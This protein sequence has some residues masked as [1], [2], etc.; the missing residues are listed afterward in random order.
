MKYYPVFIDIRNRACLVVGSGSVGTRKAVSLAGCGARVRVVT[1][2]LSS[3][4]KG[5][6]ACENISIEVRPYEP[7]DVCGMHLVFAATDSRELNLKI[8]KDAEALNILCNIADSP[9]S[10]DFIVPASVSRGDLVIAVSTSGSSP[11]LARAVRQELENRFGQEYAVFLTMMGNLRK[12]LLA[13]GHAPDE[14]RE[15]FRAMVEE[16]IPDLIRAGNETQINRVLEK[17]LGT[18]FRYKDLVF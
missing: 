7:D 1:A 6:G 15:I 18:E 17:I 14:H 5:L 2:D 10:S 11:A 8:K 4:G 3:S 12:R 16:D 13:S 9:D